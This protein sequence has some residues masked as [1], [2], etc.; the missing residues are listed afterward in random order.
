MGR[1]I[2]SHK[3]QDSSNTN[4]LKSAD[5]MNKWKIPHYYKRSSNNSP[6]NQHSSSSSSSSSSS[7]STTN[8]SIIHNNNY[9][10]EGFL[11]KVGNLPNMQSPSTVGII[12]SPKRIMSESRPRNKS[13][14]SV[15]STNSIKKYSKK[16]NKSDMVFVNYTVQ[17]TVDNKNTLQQI[18]PLQPATE[19]FKNG[20]ISPVTNEF[21]QQSQQQQQQQ[22]FPISQKLYRKRMLKIFGSSKHQKSVPILHHSTDEASV[23]LERSLSSSNLYNSSGI[24]KKSYNAFLKYN[25]LSRHDNDITTSINT[26]STVTYKNNINQVSINENTSTLNEIDIANLEYVPKSKNDPTLAQPPSTTSKSKLILNSMNNMTRSINRKYNQNTANTNNSTTDNNNNNNNNNNMANTYTNNS[27]SNNS[28]CNNHSNIIGRSI[29]VNEGLKIT[30]GGS[31]QIIPQYIEQKNLDSKAIEDND[32]SVAFS[33]LICKK[34]TEMNTSPQPLI[35][36]STSGIDNTISVANNM[37]GTNLSKP[38]TQRTASVTSLSSTNSRYSPLRTQSPARARSS[39]R[40]SS[41][42]RL[43]RDISTVYS[44]NTLLHDISPL[45]ETDTFLDSQFPS[46]NNTINGIS[47]RVSVLS[48]GSSTNANK[49]GHRRKQESISDNYKFV[50]TFGNGTYSRSASTTSVTTPN[51]TS[52]INSQTTIT[53]SGLLLTPPYVTPSLTQ[54]PNSLSTASTPSGI[55]LYNLNTVNT[56]SRQTTSYTN[57]FQ[58]GKASNDISDAL[59]DFTESLPLV[60][61]ISKEPTASNTNNHMNLSNFTDNN[62]SKFV[63]KNSYNGTYNTASNSGNIHNDRENGEASNISRADAFPYFIDSSA[64]SSGMD[65][66]MPNTLSAT[67]TTTSNSISQNF[68]INEHNNNAH[69]LS[70]DINNSKNNNN[71]NNPYG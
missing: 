36:P 6:N 15:S 25:N 22:P 5:S 1:I 49:I 3:S 16:K 50:S 55:E 33:K 63:F 34:R 52:N 42:H 53:S 45:L 38:V 11:Y 4:M 18:T 20:I 19:T 26:N 41:M 68:L 10:Q 61:A 48:S 29:S 31:G 54:L 9:I 43:S 62:E 35:P 14:S 47:K 40:G 57:H 69:L 17:D 7:F 8:P 2:H 21:S 65:S 56:T 13:V 37:N 70:K 71:N 12:N 51:T 28:N 46:G 24:S 67:T 59:A 23:A 30:L 64:N 66:L 39:T 44:P 27:S 32:A 60:K 58:Q